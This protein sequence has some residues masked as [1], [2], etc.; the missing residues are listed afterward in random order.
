MVNVC[1]ARAPREELGGLGQD[2][3]QPCA[4]AEDGRGSNLVSA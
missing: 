1:P 4:P 2:L 3:H